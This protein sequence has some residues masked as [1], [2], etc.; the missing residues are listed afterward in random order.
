M[1]P[2]KIASEQEVGCTDGALSWSSR[3][4][5]LTRVLGVIWLL[6]LIHNPGRALSATP[7]GSNSVTLAWDGSSST[8]VT[9]YRVYYGAVSGNYSNSVVVGNGT[10]N[11]V[12]GLASGATYFF[13]VTAY[14][15]SG[16]E[17]DFSN[18]I[19]YTVP[20]KLPT[21]QIRVTP[22]RQVVLTVSGP[23]GHTYDIQAT[24]DLRTWTIIGTVTVGVGGSLD[25]T[26]TN[27]AGVSKCFYRTHDIQP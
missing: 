6:A 2:M 23:I 21:M 16:L 24:Q 11:T 10:T 14:N 18:E 9:G 26:D 17:S 25:F 12:P 8:E 5:G 4:R 7:P 27:A 1:V 20:R 3:I 22:T 15:A 13:A 19:S